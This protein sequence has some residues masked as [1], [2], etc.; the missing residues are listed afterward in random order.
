MHLFCQHLLI[1][2]LFKWNK[3]MC[4]VSLS[5][6]QYNQI[7]P[8]SQKIYNLSIQNQSFIVKG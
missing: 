8:I 1:I 4:I 3:Q 2:K 6:S 5:Y 7:D